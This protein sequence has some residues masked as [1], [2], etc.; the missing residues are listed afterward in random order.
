VDFITGQGG[1]RQKQEGKG[2]RK[3]LS[4]RRKDTVDWVTGNGDKVKK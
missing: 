4:G 2:A 3:R 1:K